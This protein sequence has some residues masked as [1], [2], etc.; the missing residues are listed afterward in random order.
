MPDLGIHLMLFIG[1]NV[2]VP[3]PYDVVDALVSLEV[4]N[5]DKQRDGFQMT[6]AMGKSAPLD[7]NL[8]ASGLLDPPN[9][10]TVMVIIGAMPQV[11]IN[12]MITQHQFVPSNEPGK[13]TLHVT[14]EDIGLKFDLQEKSTT[15]PNMPDF[16]IVSQIILQN[17]LLPEVTPTTDVPLEIQ[18]VPTQQGTDLAYIKKLAE[19]NGFVF[20]TAPTLVPGLSTGYWGPENRLG[21]PQPALT[22]NMGS[23]TNVDTP[24]NFSLNALGPATPQIT[25]LLPI[26]NTPITIPVPSGLRPPL[27]LRPVPS[28]RTTIAR[29]V[30]NLNPMDAALKAVSSVTDTADAVTATGSV[31]AVRYGRALQSR[32]L[33]G[34]RGVGFNYDGV[35][36]VKQ[37]KHSIKPGEYKQSFTLTREGLGSLTPAVI[38]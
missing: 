2:P 28:L 20:Y 37:V 26:V 25:I 29:D 10:V 9:L 1:S 22:M 36:Y 31:D 16:A 4:N 5:N 33:V 15:Y 27:A 8:L 12:G 32:Q 14:G 6:F 30:A 21:V 18:R 23:D 13:S 34:V 19:R 11:L 17:G 38:P 24:I 3:A 7:Y 35:Y